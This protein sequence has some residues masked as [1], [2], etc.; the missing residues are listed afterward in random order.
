MPDPGEQA[1]GTVDPADWVDRYGDS[2]FRFALARLRNTDA[3]EEVVQETFVA[4]LRARGQYSGRG[5]EG[6]WLLGICKRKIVDFIR[7]RNRP[8]AG[9]GDELGSDPSPGLFDGKGNWRLDPRI[10]KGRPEAALERAEFWQVL[11]GCLKN[12]PRRQADV[13]ALREIDQMAGEEICKELEIT[14]SNLW[15]LLH[16]ARLGLTRCMRSHLETWGLL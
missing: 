16:R 3:A 6:A 2:L 9:S 15:V 8:D 5:E 13:F 14:P 4:A 11:R 1:D 10:T 12:L 7:Q